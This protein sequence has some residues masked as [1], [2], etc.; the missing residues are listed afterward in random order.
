[1]SFIASLP[2]KYRT[3][4]LGIL[5]FL[6]RT[7]RL[8]GIPRFVVSHLQAF[9]MND[10]SHNLLFIGQILTDRLN[11]Y[12]ILAVAVSAIMALCDNLKKWI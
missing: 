9:I 6:L 11:Y 12:M 5:S 10:S 7:I 2:F 8:M 3:A 1:M 4:L